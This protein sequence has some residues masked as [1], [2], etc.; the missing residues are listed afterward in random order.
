MR[1]AVVDRDTGFTAY[2][3]TVTVTNVEPSATLSNN[4]PIGEGATAQVSWAGV[5][6]PSPTDAAAG[7]RY[8]YDFGNDGTYDVGSG[9]YATASALAAVDPGR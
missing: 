5:T 2:S 7:T 9:T 8:G 4:G 3:A 6:D 1:V